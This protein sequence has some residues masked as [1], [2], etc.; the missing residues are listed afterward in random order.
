MRYF[1]EVVL[2]LLCLI[3]LSCFIWVAAH[4]TVATECEKLGAFYVGQ[5]VYECKLKGT[6]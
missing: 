5:K 3:A 1:V 2:P 4:S 6:P